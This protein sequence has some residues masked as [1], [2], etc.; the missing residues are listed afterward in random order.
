[1]DFPKRILKLYTPKR[2]VKTKSSESL[3]SLH[4]RDDSDEYD[5]RY[6]TIQRV[7]LKRQTQFICDTCNFPIEFYPDIDVGNNEV[8]EIKCN[9]CKGCSIFDKPKTKL[10]N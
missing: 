6:H 7:E 8:C 10:K 2:H 9:D 1:M 5:P 3:Q 4:S